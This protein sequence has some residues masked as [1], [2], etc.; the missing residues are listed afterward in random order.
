MKS[1]CSFLSSH[2]RT[3]LHSAKLKTELPMAVS[4]WEVTWT[5]LHLKTETCYICNCRYVVS[6]LIMQKT[7]PLLFSNV[8]NERLHSNG[9]SMDPT[10]SQPLDSHLS[11]PSALPTAAQQWATNIRP[12][13]ECTYARRYLSCR[14]PAVHVTIFNCIV[15]RKDLN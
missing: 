14:C 10:E 4:Y 8:F 1:S 12:I 9:R 15:Q 7:Q 2:S 11:S 5:E 6:A 3:L 13:V